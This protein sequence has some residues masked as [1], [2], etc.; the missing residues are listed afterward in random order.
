MKMPPSPKIEALEE[1]AKVMAKLKLDKLKGYKK[2]K[3]EDPMEEVCE[4][5]EECDEEEVPVLEAEAVEEDEDAPKSFSKMMASLEK[6]K[7]KKH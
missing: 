3:A 4:D 6:K 5:G 2:T 1:L 7:N